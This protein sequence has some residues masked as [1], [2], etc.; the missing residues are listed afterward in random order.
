MTKEKEAKEPYFHLASAIAD[1]VP[2]DWQ[3][4]TQP[5]DHPP[6][7]IRNLEIIEHMARLSNHAEPKQELQEDLRDTLFSWGHLDIHEKIGE[8]GYGE[9]YQA[10]DRT[11]QRHVALKLVRSDRAVI[12]GERSYLEE[13][14][15][16]ARVRHPN[17]LAIHG[18]DTFDG[19]V[20]LWCD[21]VQGET[22]VGWIAKHGPC[23]YAL[24]LDIA[25]QITNAL[26]TVH[27]ADMVHGDIKMANVMLQN[28]KHIVLMD[29]GAVTDLSN[30][31]YGQGIVG[32]PMY[33]APEVMSGESPTPRADLFSLG[34]LLYRL[35]TGKYPYSYS[36][37][38]ELLDDKRTRSYESFP[39]NINYPKPWSNIIDACLSPSVQARPD[40]E[41]VQEMLIELQRAPVRRRRRTLIMAALTFLVMVAAGFAIFSWRLSIQAH[42]ARQESQTAESLIH[43]MVD[44]FDSARPAVSL[45]NQVSAQD[46]VNLAI[47]QQAQDMDLDPL[48]KAR[49][50]SVLGTVMRQLG[51]N[52]QAEQLLRESV[53]KLTQKAGSAHLVTLGARSELIYVLSLKGKIKEA[54]DLG[55]ALLDETINSKPNQ[56]A[57][58]LVRV[59]RAQ[60]MLGQEAK[61]K[62]LFTQAVKFVQQHEVNYW[63]A[64]QTY[65]AIGDFEMR[66]GSLESA[67][68]HFQHVQRLL[69]KNTPALHPTRANFEEAIAHLEERK[70][71][72]SQALIHSQ[73]A[74]D[75]NHAIF[76]N[77]HPNLAASYSN[78]GRIL[79]SLG[80]YHEAGEHFSLA[81]KNLVQNIPEDSAI[82]ATHRL[83]F[84]MYFL[85]MGQIH[86]AQKTLSPA[87][88]T[89]EQVYGRWS[90]YS[91]HAYLANGNTSMAMTQFVDAE[92]YL[93]MAIAIFEQSQEYKS[94]LA[95]AR[96]NLGELYTKAGRYQQADACFREALC[97][98]KE[99][100]GESHPLYASIL[101]YRVDLNIERDQL[102]AAR[103]DLENAQRIIIDNQPALELDTCRIQAYQCALSYRDRPMESKQKWAE[104]RTRMAELLAQEEPPEI[105]KF[106]RWLDMN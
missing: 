17:V 102:D 80:R 91:A 31:K 9:V 92:F 64:A 76:T 67:S 71:N 16:L 1:G 104:I 50:Q 96:N 10:W 99:Y 22:L 8:G 32:T 11:L 3:E 97:V 49:I 87:L 19:R 57:E 61:A 36:T 4:G 79:L 84:S 55:M 45:G 95:I 38:S 14:R 93:E 37:F 78:T 58:A 63:L 7:L 94:S 35:S 62:D 75:I 12:I 90:D 43:F 46:I 47:H 101:L 41:D 44:M 13:A 66:H 81:L 29:F 5:F 85:D 89:Y 6:S 40:A 68:D 28:E 88:A 82:L 24:S 98:A 103:A 77:N 74:L 65:Q 72:L 2:I 20:G 48:V 23:P 100:I 39:K 53:T 34:V 33:M 70:G 60:D 25:R 83:N 18:A 56:H 21:L 26:V 86:L 42:K 51:D 15:R 69:E 30:P 73:R 54:V 52:E 106:D 105:K 27:D 59:A